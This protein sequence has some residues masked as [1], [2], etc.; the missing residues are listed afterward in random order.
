VPPD[1]FAIEVRTAIKDQVPG[2][3]VVRERFAQ[4]LNDPS[5]GRVLGNIAVQDTPTVMRNDE[6]A[7]ENADCQ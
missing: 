1:H 6:E 2:R 7:V 3:R 4:L 5:A